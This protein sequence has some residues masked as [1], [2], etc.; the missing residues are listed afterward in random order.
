MRFPTGTRAANLNSIILRRVLNV[1]LAE[2][3][4][5]TAYIALHCLWGKGF[6]SASGCFELNKSVSVLA[7]Y[8]SELLGPT[9]TGIRALDDLTSANPCHGVPGHLQVPG[10]SVEEIGPRSYHHFFDTP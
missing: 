4:A 6:F 3:S 8:L 1:I 2:Q 9:L 10:S 5:D 7:E